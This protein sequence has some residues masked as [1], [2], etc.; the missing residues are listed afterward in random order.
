MNLHPAIARAR[1]EFAAKPVVRVGV[2]VIVAILVGYWLFEVQ[3]GRLATV[4]GDHAA[5]ADRL[6]RSRVLLGRDDWTERLAA[7]RGWEQDMA[8]RFWHADNAGL[9]QARLRTDIEALLTDLGID[10][11]TIRLGLSQPVDD[12]PA[13]PSGRAL[14]RIQV[15]V[16]G[17]AR[18]R[19]ILPFLQAVATYPNKLVEERL[20]VTRPSNDRRG[21]TR[22]DMLLSAYFVVG[23]SSPAGPAPAAS[24]PPAA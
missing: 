9:A 5:A 19:A 23:E 7:A 16:S 13:D 12:I 22:F 6:A 3:A 1:D 17:T 2:W 8:G 15:Q 20:T 11:T 21:D 10:K 14:W 24:T 4:A 18:R